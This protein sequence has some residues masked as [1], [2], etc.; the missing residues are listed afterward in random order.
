MKSRVKIDAINFLF[1]FFHNFFSFLPVI[2]HSSYTEWERNKYVHMKLKFGTKQFSVQ[3]FVHSM[4]YLYFNFS[5]YLIRLV[6]MIASRMTLDAF[7]IF[8]STTILFFLLF[9]YFFFFRFYFLVIYS[10]S[11]T[12]TCTSYECNYK[13]SSDSSWTCD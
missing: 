4:V 13:T 2:Y 6:H 7:R 8:I 3:I 9:Y 5:A 11:G 12:R 10:L 1:S